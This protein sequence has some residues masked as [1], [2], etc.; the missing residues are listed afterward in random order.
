MAEGQR[1][2]SVPG[3]GPQLAAAL[4]PKTCTTQ[5]VLPAAS[6]LAC[7][8]TSEVDLQAV[9]AAE[10]AR[11]LKLPMVTANALV[12]ARPL[13]QNLTQVITPSSQTDVTLH[14]EPNKPSVDAL[15]RNVKPECLSQGAFSWI[16]DMACQN[17]FYAT[18]GGVLSRVP[19]GR[20]P[21][22][23]SGRRLSREALPMRGF[24]IDGR[25]PC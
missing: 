13:P 7:K 17:A 4:A 16:L 1:L 12:S 11:R 2:S 25:A 10:I 24:R 19:A 3:I 23:E 8:S 14:N 6:P 22:V 5:L 15:G 21:R 18:L 9:S 20:C